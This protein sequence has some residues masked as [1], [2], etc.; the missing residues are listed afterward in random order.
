MQSAGPFA[1][2]RARASPS[3]TQRAA[4]LR[5]QARC[6]QFFFLAS[7]FWTLC[8]AVN[9][10]LSVVRREAALFKF[11]PL[12][13]TLSWGAP[14]LLTLSVELAGGFGQTDLWCWIRLEENTLRWLTF[15][16]PLLAVMLSVVVLGALSFCALSRH[17]QREWQARQAS[18]DNE[19]RSTTSGLVQIELMGYLV[20]FLLIRIPSLVHRV[21][22][23]LG[24]PPSF[25]L[26]VLH[27]LGSPLQGTINCCL[28][29]SNRNVRHFLRHASA[30]A[31]A[32]ADADEP[33]QD[34]LLGGG[35]G[36]NLESFPPHVASKDVVN[37]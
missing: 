6:Q 18:G 24:R 20:V 4:P 36:S 16:G 21:C 11:E 19:Q 5:A 1:S 8:F 29:F 10:Y 37:M 7:F 9:N 27:A 23:L 13:H 26:E 2:A 15:Y 14:A 31:A 22:E 3:E 17:R 28:F 25:T 34:A 32:R 33:E 30:A 12:Y 35:G